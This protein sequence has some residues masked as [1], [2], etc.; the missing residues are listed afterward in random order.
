[1]LNK[2]PKMPCSDSGS[3]FNYS[4]HIFLFIFK[5]FKGFFFLPVNA[6]PLVLQF[7][8]ILRFLVKLH[9]GL[10]S[11][12]SLES[13]II[14]LYLQ[15]CRQYPLC[16]VTWCPAGLTLSFKTPW[17]IKDNQ[18]EAHRNR[19]SVTFYCTK[20]VQWHINRTLVVEGNFFP[21]Q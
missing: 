17:D 3:A 6:L 9:C 1:M 10:G 5:I 2:C 4:K 14:K 19:V 20:N 21:R 11:S 12:W 7:V 15:L 8:Y 13:L 18:G 16:F